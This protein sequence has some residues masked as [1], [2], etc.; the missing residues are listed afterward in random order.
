MAESILD[1]IMKAATR[2][3]QT[4]GRLDNPRVHLDPVDY[5]ELRKEGFIAARR[6]ETDVGMETVSVATPAGMVKCWPASPPMLSHPSI[7]RGSTAL[8]EMDGRST[9]VVKQKLIHIRG[10]PATEGVGRSAQSLKPTF[11]TEFQKFVGNEPKRIRGV[12]ADLVVEDEPHAIS[13]DNPLSLAIARGRDLDRLG[14]TYGLVRG[15]GSSIAAPETDAEFR[16][17]IHASIRGPEPWVDVKN[18]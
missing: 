10:A 16:D 7:R 18:D 2:E 4:C 1:A 6:T 9:S 11:A 15:P 17:R 8:L 12:K 3:L 5:A 14:S 13:P